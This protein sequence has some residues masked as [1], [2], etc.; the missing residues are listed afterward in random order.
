MIKFPTLLSWQ[1]LLTD[2]I[3]WLTNTY[4]YYY[5]DKNHYNY[6][7]VPFNFG[8]LVLTNAINIFFKLKPSSK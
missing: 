5:I 2:M 4:V 8:I 1:R 7:T 6:H 3:D